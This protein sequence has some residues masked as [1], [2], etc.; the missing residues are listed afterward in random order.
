MSAERKRRHREESTHERAKAERASPLVIQVDLNLPA[1]LLP[2]ERELL[3]RHIQGL[4]DSV[5]LNP[6]SD[7]Q[8]E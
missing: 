2:W 8:E 5:L 3:V 6:Q 1:H 7:G 4:L